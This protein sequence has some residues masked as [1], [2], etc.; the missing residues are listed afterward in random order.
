MPARMYV[1]AFVTLGREALLTLWHLPFGLQHFTGT[2]HYCTRTPSG[3]SPEMYKSFLTFYVFSVYCGIYFAPPLFHGYAYGGLS[4]FVNV[5]VLR[6]GTSRSPVLVRARRSS[7][8]QD[9]ITTEVR[10]TRSAAR[11]VL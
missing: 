9:A 4:V 10:A 5:P 2:A 7:G 6:E 8:P 3:E 1:C 11:T